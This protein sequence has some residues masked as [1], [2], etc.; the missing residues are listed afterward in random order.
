MLVLVLVLERRR[1]EVIV[2]VSSRAK[3][4]HWRE[5]PFVVNACLPVLVR[6]TDLRNIISI[7]RLPH[8]KYGTCDFI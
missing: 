1:E 8:V 7:T 4:R 3:R 5:G 6:G 2:F